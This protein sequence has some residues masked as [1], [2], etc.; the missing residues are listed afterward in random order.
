MHSCSA[1]QSTANAL[2]RAKVPYTPCRR[3]GRPWTRFRL[4]CSGCRGSWKQQRRRRQPASSTR[5]SCRG[6]SPKHTP[7]WP[8]TRCHPTRCP[9]ASTKPRTDVPLHV[10]YHAL[11]H[12][13][14][15]QACPRPVYVTRHLHLDLDSYCVQVRGVVERL[16]ALDAEHS[17]LQAEAQLLRECPAAGGPQVPPADPVAT[18]ARRLPADADATAVQVPRPCMILLLCSFHNSCA[19]LWYN[20]AKRTPTFVLSAQHG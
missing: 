18:A 19:N 1:H 9:H 5:R 17:A 8:A 16:A 12:L 7:R 20:C 2:L 13:P 4:T 10:A 6:C 11:V 14:C 3:G 15:S